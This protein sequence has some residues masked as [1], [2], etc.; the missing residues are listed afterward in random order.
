VQGEFPETATVRNTLVRDR[1]DGLRGS[2]PGGKPA[3]THFKRVEL[4]RGAT[5]VEA[6]LETGRTHQVRIHLAELGHPVLGDRLYGPRVA[7]AAP[8]LALHAWRLA[9]KHP[10]GGK[11]VK[12]EVPLADDMDRL[13]RDLAI[14]GG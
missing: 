10:F 11:E 14:T 1:G 5:L 6:R 9:F 4:L 7:N 3:A 8:R 13:R 12:V 2:G